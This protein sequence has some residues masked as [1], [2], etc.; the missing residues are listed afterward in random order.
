VLVAS[1]F[2]QTLRGF[3]SRVHSEKRRLGQLVAEGRPGVLRWTDDLGEA[4]KVARARVPALP[5]PEHLRTLITSAPERPVHLATVHGDLHAGNLFVRANGTD[6]IIIDYG[7]VASE[8]PLVLDPACLEVSL[9]FPPGDAESVLFA[10]P[11]AEHTVRSLYRWP[12]RGGGALEGS[13]SW[14]PQQEWLAQAV[15][16]IRMQAFALEPDAE[17]YGLVLGSYLLRYAS[18]ADHASV[19][20]RALAYECGCQLVLAAVPRGA[21]AGGILAGSP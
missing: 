14:P 7:S 12:L 3:L 20:D 15:R 16:A 9:A 5:T 1:L 8:A 10:D 17:V 4:A 18:F 21:C 2:G 13:R 11:E 6:V 19:A